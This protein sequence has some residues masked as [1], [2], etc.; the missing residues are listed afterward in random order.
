MFVLVLVLWL[1]RIF[2]RGRV[3]E[4]FLGGWLCLLVWDCGYLAEEGT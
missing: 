4:A 1:F 3:S 2:S